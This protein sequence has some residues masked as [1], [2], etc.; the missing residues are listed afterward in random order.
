MAKAK[1]SLEIT[2]TAE[3][4]TKSFRRFTIGG[5]DALGAGSNGTVYVPLSE[6]GDVQA[7]T[8]TGTLGHDQQV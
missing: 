2:F 1:N 5:L 8:I 7:F 4:D 6:V 3:K